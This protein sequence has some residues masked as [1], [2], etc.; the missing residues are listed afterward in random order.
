MESFHLALIGCG[1]AAERYYLPALQEIAPFLGQVYFVDP[2]TKLAT[3]LASRIKGGEVAQNHGAILKKVHGAIVCVPNHLHY[4]ITLDLLRSGVH[5]LCEKPLAETARE[6]RELTEEASKSKLV[7]CVNNTRRRF[8]SFIEVKKILDRGEI[9]TL[10][11]LHFQEGNT[12]AWPSATGFYVNPKETDRGV[13]ADIGSHV[14]DLVCWWLGEKPELI[15]FQDDSFGGPES[16]AHMKARVKE[17]S[18]NV[19]LNR[20]CDIDSRFIIKG[21]LGEIK[22]NVF[23]WQNLTIRLN[24]G[25]IR[26]MR[27]KPKY[28]NF[29]KFIPQIVKNFLEAALQQGRPFI[30]GRDVI[31]SISL[32]E[33][34]YAS[35]TRFHMPWNTNLKLPPIKEGRLLVTGATGFIGCRVVEMVHLSGNR[36]VRA[37]IRNWSSAAR[38]GRFPVDIVPMDLLDPGQ[39]GKALD[40]VSEI[41]HCAYGPAG[42]TVEGT[43]NLLEAA[44]KRPIKRIVHLSTIEVY[45]NADGSVTE[46]CSISVTKNEYNQTKVEAEKICWEFYEKGLPLTIL[47]PTI[48]YGP[49][50]RNWT[51]HFAQ[52]LLINQWYLSKS[53]GTGKCNLIFVDDLV[54]GILTALDHPKAVGEA[55]NMNGPEMVSWNDYFQR[56]NDKMDL[57]PFKLKGDSAA[58]FHGL[59]MQPL[60]HAG[61]L[62]KNYY[63]GPVKKLANNF[64]L[65]KVIMKKAEYNLRATASPETLKLYKREVVYDMEKSKRLLGFVPET[66]LDKGLTLTCQWLSQQG[67]LP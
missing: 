50:S 53:Q 6:A 37:G 54:R 67:L 49:F 47:R 19:F 17:C 63:M 52:L 24:S 44:A 26:R 5:V 64:P 13:L 29:P 57:P 45:G 7:L 9:G 16:I 20:L 22:G 33:D 46:D 21:D 43:R 15:E 28:N 55:F 8:P 40:G 31:P 30:S 60:R 25:D 56:F 62:V 18:I 42:V 32:V 3:N 27:L 14:I 2:N 10:R 1:A 36:K 48:V 23:D 41:I 61:R 66:S 65:V 34:C 35:R 39:I 51:L 12:F 38:L 58:E 59:L 4:K 11:S